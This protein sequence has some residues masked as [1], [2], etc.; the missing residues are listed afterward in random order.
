MRADAMSRA[1][2]STTTPPAQ[3]ATSAN[4]RRTAIDVDP[5]AC[6]AEGVR[7]EDGVTGGILGGAA[8]RVNPAARGACNLG[9]RGPHAD[10]RGSTST[11]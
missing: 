6:A 2:A 3:F 4:T 11:R 1:A 8:G 9:A 7:L 5:T 10:P